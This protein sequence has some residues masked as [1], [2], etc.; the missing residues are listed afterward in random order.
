MKSELIA[1]QSRHPHG[2]LGEVV[3]RVMSLETDSVNRRAVHQLGLAPGESVLEV[4]CGHGRTLQKLLRGGAGIASGIDPSDVMFRLARRRLRH[5][6]REGRSDVRL[7][8][9][10]H[11]PFENHCFDAALAVHVVYFWTD[12]RVEFSEI[13]RVLRSGG[14]LL[15]GF[16]PRDEEV[17]A[18]LPSSVY[19]LRSIEE[20]T[21][22]LLDAGFRDVRG[23][24][25]CVGGVAMGWVLARA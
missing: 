3:A 2:W 7:A 14:R 25:D 23:E 8:E 22:L 18:D 15:V 11:L 13:R 21:A 19:A 5:E 12:P 10:R 9:A 1:R 20:T 16:R 24:L 4:G 17:V 6:I